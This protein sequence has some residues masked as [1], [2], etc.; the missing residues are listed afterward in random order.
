MSDVGFNEIV[1][2]RDGMLAPFQIEIIKELKDK[3]IMV[4]AI[5]EDYDSVE[6]GVDTENDAMYSVVDYSCGEPDEEPDLENIIMGEMDFDDVYEGV[7]SLDS[8]SE[9]DK[10]DILS[11]IGDVGAVAVAELARDR[12]LEANSENSLSI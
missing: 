12:R 3:G 8:V 9:E 1:E 4:Y 7:M 6:V 5:A 10:E 2:N 11:V